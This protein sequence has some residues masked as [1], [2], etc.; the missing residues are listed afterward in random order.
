[1]PGEVRL[2]DSSSINTDEGFSYVSGY[3]V[4]CVDDELVPLCNSTM[5][6]LLELTNI[7]SRSSN[8]TC[9]YAHTHK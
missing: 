9:T 8:L 7:C 3:P 6:G 5:P 2:S 1:M 4:L